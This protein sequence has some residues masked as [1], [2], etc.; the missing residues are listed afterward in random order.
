M[1]RILPRGTKVYPVRGK[2]ITKLWPCKPVRLNRHMTCHVV[3]SRSSVLWLADENH[4]AAMDAKNFSKFKDAAK[5]SFAPV[6]P[7]KLYVKDPL[8]P[9][10][11]YVYGFIFQLKD[12]L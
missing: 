4:E 11:I 7:D 1:N 9:K 12:L 10:P 5:W 6:S 8:D 2:N 3:P